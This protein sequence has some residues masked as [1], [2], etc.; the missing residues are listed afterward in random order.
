MTNI[1]LLGSEGQDKKWEKKLSLG[2]EEVRLGLGWKNRVII[3]HNHWLN[4]NFSFK[5]TY[6]V[7]KLLLWKLI[8][9]T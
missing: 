1:G 7:L 8:H 6:I 2:L 3:Y 4:P 5:F 9:M